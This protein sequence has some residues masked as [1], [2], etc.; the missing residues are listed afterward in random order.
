M[1]E[2]EYPGVYVEE[3][4]VIPKPIVGV[5]TS[6]TGFVGASEKGDLNK[7][8]LV[9]NW[10]QFVESFGRYTTS[11]P[12]L[13]PAVRGFFANGGNRCY[14]VRVPESAGDGDYIGT[15]GGSK[16][17][18]GLQALKDI[19]EINIVCVP[20]VTSQSV[21]VAVI[22]HCELMNDRFC[23]LD[24]VKNADL[25]TIQ[26]QKNSVVS[27]QGFAALYYPWIKVPIET[28]ENDKIKIIQAFVPPSGYIAG[29]YARTDKQK[30]VHKAPANEKI[31]GALEVSLQIT[32]IQLDIL[33]PKSINCIRHFPGKG[34]YVWGART[35]ASCPLWKYVPVRRL[36]LFIEES[37]HKGTKWVVFEPNNESLWEKIRKNVG[38]FMQD[39]YRKGALQ[40]RSS[41][42][43]YFVKCDEET[44]TQNDINLGIVNIE[45]G[46]APVK[47]L[48][49][50]IFKIKHKTKKA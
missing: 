30:G 23:I 8:I 44:T 10:R 12:F 27:D 36:C 43:A 33:N 37:I 3:V 17:R 4:E 40:G 18:T 6:T 47:P 49:F 41:D 32:K 38:T 9:T 22:K 46:F 14:V 24:P 39:L 19:D 16:N 31:S 5:S 13:A 20:G 15:D 50:V 21:Q 7:P 1:P 42:E 25:G 29:V 35:T 48:E 11:A 34:I 28:T 26:S 45:V 2:Y